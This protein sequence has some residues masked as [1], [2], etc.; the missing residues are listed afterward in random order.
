MP[1]K[2]EENVSVKSTLEVWA[3]QWLSLIFSDDVWT[4][5]E[6]ASLGLALHVNS[7]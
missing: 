6:V 1:N 2:A 5:N 3:I 7:A 4:S